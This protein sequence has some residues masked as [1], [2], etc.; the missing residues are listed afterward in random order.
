MFLNLSSC[1]VFGK[2]YL[3]RKKKKKEGDFQEQGHVLEYQKHGVDAEAEKK[4]KNLQYV[5]AI[6]IFE[7]AN[8]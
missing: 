1:Q 4:K 3:Y 6:G 2:Y 5:T 7:T 8:K